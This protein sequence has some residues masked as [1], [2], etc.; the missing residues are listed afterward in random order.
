MDRTATLRETNEHPFPG[1]V[2]PRRARLCIP[3]LG[4]GLVRGTALPVL[5]DERLDQLDALER[6]VVGAGRSF[7]LLR[8]LSGCCRADFTPCGIV[9][10]FLRNLLRIFDSFFYYLAGAVAMAGTLK[11][12]RLGDRAADTVVMRKT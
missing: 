12:P 5:V 7:A 6:R 1:G 3:A 8:G 9:A 10:G 4:T 11:R 2:S